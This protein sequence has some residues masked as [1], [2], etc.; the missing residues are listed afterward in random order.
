M[1][2]TYTEGG[3]QVITQ[4]THGILAAQIASQWEKIG[5]HNREIETILAIAE[6]DD[7]EVELD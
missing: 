1:I 4:R 6:H 2:V 7:A 3:W 5:V